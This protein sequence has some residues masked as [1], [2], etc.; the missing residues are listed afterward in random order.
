MR[1]Q[2][3]GL[4]WTYQCTDRQNAISQEILAGHETSRFLYDLLDS[5]PT[6]GLMKG[7]LLRLA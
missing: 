5:L 6:D 3:E 7:R 1:Q 4:W 2:P